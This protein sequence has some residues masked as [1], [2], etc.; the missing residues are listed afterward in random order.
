MKR[1][2]L[3]YY[4]LYAI[5]SSITLT[6]GIFLICLQYKGLSLAEVSMY[7]VLFNIVT[8]ISEIPTGYMGD[9]FGKRNSLILGNLILII[10]TI[11]MIFAKNKMLLIVAGGIEALAYTFIS[12]SDSALL[13]ELLD[14]QGNEKKYL[15]VNSQLLA[16]Q[17]LLIGGSIGVG[18]KLAEYSLKLPYII[19]GIFLFVSTIFLLRIE[20]KCSQ[21][22]ECVRITEKNILKKNILYKPI[23][24]FVIF[25]V[26]VS[27]LDGVFCAY[28]NLN[29]IILGEVGIGISQIGIFF[30][31][32][33]IINSLAYILVNFI[34]RFIRRI[35]IIMGALTVQSICMCFLAYTENK[36]VFYLLSIIACFVPEI[37]Y[38]VAESIIQDSISETNRA[39]IL[40]IMSLLRSACSAGIYMVFGIGLEIISI[41]TFLMIICV[42]LFSCTGIGFFCIR[43]LS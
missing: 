14:K 35:P 25:F 29:Q 13:Y 41:K 16:I 21:K 38:T 17:S 4:Y 24:V 23:A 36:T 7:S 9:K 32:S 22:Q 31:I 33:Y 10:Q 39:T 19:T 3:A 5:G 18:A 11:I 20:E 34:S 27:A 37:F 15:N 2:H 8:S 28:Y 6:R 26:G 40:S 12:G 43:R 1:N 30:S 42:C